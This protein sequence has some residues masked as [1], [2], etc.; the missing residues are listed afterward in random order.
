MIRQGPIKLDDLPLFADDMTIAE[1]IVGKSAA[2]RW[3]KERLPTL[4]QKPGFP[5][6][7][8]F[9]GGRP[10]KLVILFYDRYLKLTNHGGSKAVDG[11]EDEGVWE[12]SRRRA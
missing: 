2:P 6:V 7:D 3:V 12:K 1:A 5:Q 11:P 9:H 10:V 8:D 4:S